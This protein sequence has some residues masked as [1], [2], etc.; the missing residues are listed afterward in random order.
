MSEPD[1]L[2]TNPF[3][4]GKYIDGEAFLKDPEIQRQ[5]EWLESLSPERRATYER[6]TRLRDD[7]GPLDFDVIEELRK[8]REGQDKRRV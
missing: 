4:G 7:I 5:L 1:Y 8:M 2:R 6:I 3:D